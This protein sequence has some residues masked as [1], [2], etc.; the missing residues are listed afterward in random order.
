MEQWVT[1][2]AQPSP[3][4]IDPIR[5][6]VWVVDMQNAYVKKGGM[7]DLLG[8]DI[9]GAQKIIEPINGIIG[10][11]R[12][13]EIKIIY[14]ITW[15]TKDNADLRGPNYAP[16]H[17]NISLRMPERKQICTFSHTWGAEIV[18]E[19][20]PKKGDVIT[21]KTRYDAFFQTNLETTLTACGIKYLIVVGTATNICV[22]DS[23]RGAFSRGYFPILA[24]DATA[25]IGPP[26][27]QQAAE[28]NI[29][30]CYG[31]VADSEQIID[32]INLK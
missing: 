21:H 6:A 27:M 32:A 20:K 24:T 10:V 11:A 28:F 7:M 22:E 30:A 3:L 25:P 29:K 9:S 17:K 31:W 19:L 18:D 5:T 12:A 8:L 26:F 4:E 13:N 16:W 14:T 15:H 23:I 1:I 2:Q